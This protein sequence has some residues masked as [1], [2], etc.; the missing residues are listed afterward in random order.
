LTVKNLILSL[1]CILLSANVCGASSA[2]LLSNPNYREGF[3]KDATGGAGHPI[4]TVTSEAAS[5]PGTLDSCFQPGDA[6][7][8]KTIVLAVNKVTLPGTRTIGSNVTIDGCANGMNG[9]TVEQTGD[10]KRGLVVSG[11]SSNVIVRCLNLR[12]TGTPSSYATEFDNL[13]LDGDNPTPISNVF[14]DRITSVQASD[15]AL[16]ITGNVENVTVQRSLF[17]GNAITMLIKYDT[18]RNISIHHNVFTRNGERNPQIKGDMK[19]LDFVNNVVHLNNVPYY[20]DGSETSPYGTRIFS[21]GSGCDSPGNVIANLVNNAYIDA[22][23]AIE[24]LTGPG[25]GSN[26]GTSIGGNYSS[27]ASNCPASPKAVPNTIPA[28]YAVTTLATDQLKSRL[29]P[30]VGSPN[31]TPTDQQRIDD[32]AAV[33]PGHPP[34]SLALPRG[35]RIEE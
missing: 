33:L 18:R 10:A 5:G 14:I 2:N 12:G 17:Y 29:L 6:A 31:R 11:G 20:P 1:S 16:D 26:A 24:L 25:G 21:C 15:G 9:V 22:T 4:C 13:A 19:L 35:I 34:P 32:V 8:N 23:A 27:P 3:G 7:S 30:C 28:A